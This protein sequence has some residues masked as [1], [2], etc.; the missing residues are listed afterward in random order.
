WGAAKTRWPGFSSAASSG[1]AT[2]SP[3]ARGSAMSP[4]PSDT[5]ERERRRNEIL[6]ACLEDPQLAAEVVAFFAD[7]DRF[8]RLDGPLRRDLA[9]A[10]PAPPSDDA[11]VAGSGSTSPGSLPAPLRCFGDYELLGEVARGGMGVVYKARQKGLNR[12]VALKMIKAGDL[13]NADDLH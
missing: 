13:A 1:C 7:Q 2:C 4:D 10:S 3:K 11:T 8:G 6:A 12:L 5:S 9:E